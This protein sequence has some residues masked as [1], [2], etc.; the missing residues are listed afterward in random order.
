MA[1]NLS[2]TRAASKPLPTA[3]TSSLHLAVHRLETM[4]ER[5]QAEV[6]TL[7]RSHSSLRR[8]YAK[9]RDAP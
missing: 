1:A 4:V 8:R 7:Q 3:G 5:L 6:K 9:E 2:P